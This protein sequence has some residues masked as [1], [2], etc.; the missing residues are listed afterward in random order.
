MIHY[1]DAARAVVA[2]LLLEDQARTSGSGKLF[3]A[4][5]GTPITRIDICKA[6]VQCP[7][8]KDA[9]RIPSFQGDPDLVDGKKYDVSKIRAE[10]KDWEQKFPTFEQFMTT[11]TH[12][13]EMNIGELIREMV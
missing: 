9:C 10:L 7:D 4:S 6:S 3:V 5:D 8:Y 1:D 12:Q 2:A 11:S 13:E